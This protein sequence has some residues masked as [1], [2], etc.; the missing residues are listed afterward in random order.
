M[1]KN[2][3]WASGCGSYYMNSEGKN[4]TLYPRLNT[5]FRKQTLRVDLEEYE[6]LVGNDQTTDNAGFN[7]FTQ[8]K[9]KEIRVNPLNLC[10]PWS[11]TSLRNAT[12]NPPDC[13]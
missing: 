6:V 3:A 1:F 9:I 11:N 2:T 8:I 5:E 10:H 12:R 4:T 13:P 7:G